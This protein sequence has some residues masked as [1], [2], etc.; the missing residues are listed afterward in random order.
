MH[1]KGITGVKSKVARNQQ[2]FTKMQ[3]KEKQMKF[4]NEMDK[5]WELTFG[6]ISG[7]MKH[8]E[9]SLKERK[10]SVVCCSPQRRSSTT[11][12]TQPAESPD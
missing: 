6:N 11:L 8:K 9:C 12:M 10:G 3:R 4:L 5:G 7:Y 1:H 2:H